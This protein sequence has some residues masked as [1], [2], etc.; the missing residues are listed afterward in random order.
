MVDLFE[1]CSNFAAK[2]RH[3]MYPI[4]KRDENRKD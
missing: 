3:N 1:F 2:V 4:E